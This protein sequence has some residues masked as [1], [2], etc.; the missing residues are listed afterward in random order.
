L[1]D[2]PTLLEANG[3]EAAA[4]DKR[5]ESGEAK[6]IEAA[7]A[8]VESGEAKRGERKWALM[9]LFTHMTSENDSLRFR[10][11]IASF[12]SEVLKNESHLAR[13]LVK[14]E[15]VIASV[16]ALIDPSL[17]SVPPPDIND[18]THPLA[19]LL[20][21][22]AAASNVARS[23]VAGHGAEVRGGGGRV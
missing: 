3:S 23:L 2:V 22:A 5:A 11:A 9:R 20:S 19:R 1:E 12:I 7:E 8:P 16:K 6:G 4:G 18:D 13:V 14:K 15:F 10:T 17:A 21:L